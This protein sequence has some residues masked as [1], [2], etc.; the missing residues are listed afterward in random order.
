MLLAQLA[1]VAV[2][3]AGATDPN[4]ATPLSVRDYTP[5]CGAV[6]PIVE[7]TVNPDVGEYDAPAGLCH[8]PIRT[9]VQA[10]PVGSGYRAALSLDGAP[11]GP[12]STAFAVAAGQVTGPCTTADV[13]SLTVRRRESFALE[14][15]HDLTDEDGLPITV[16][17]WRVY[18]DGQRLVM[19]ATAG[20][21]AAD[22]C[23]PVTFS[24]SEDMAGTY[25]YTLRAVSG[26]VEGPDSL[27]LTVT[28]LRGR[29]S[30]A[31]HGRVSSP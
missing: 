31:G 17:E 25:V 16:D 12:L 7:V 21:V 13:V 5:T 24:W 9:Q 3:A 30:G 2:F 19:P 18:R 10:L 1:T 27:A 14:W 20:A 23:V 26:G 29:P 15:G 6:T 11:F 28:V 22:G 8:V 4:A